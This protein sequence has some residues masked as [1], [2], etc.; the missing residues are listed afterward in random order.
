MNSKT[1]YLI[2][3]Q[4]AKKIQSKNQNIGTYEVKK[5][6]LSCLDDRRFA[7]DDGIYTLAYFKIVKRKKNA[8]R[9]P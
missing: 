9:F 6:S 5:K 7:L 1:F 2:N 4:K 8:K 3:R